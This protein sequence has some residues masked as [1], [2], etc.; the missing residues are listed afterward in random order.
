[1]GWGILRGVVGE[2]RGRAARSDGGTGVRVTRPA[3]QALR[4]DRQRTYALKVI[5]TQEVQS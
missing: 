3:A 1:M 4:G 5:L 2:F